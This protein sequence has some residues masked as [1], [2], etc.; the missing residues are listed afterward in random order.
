MAAAVDN[1]EVSKNPKDILSDY[2]NWGSVK[3]DYGEAIEE[4]VIRFYNLYNPKDK[5]LGPNSTNPFSPYQI[6]PSFEGDLAP[7][8]NGSQTPPDKALREK[9]VDIDVTKEIPFNKDAA[10]IGNVSIG[11]LS[12][13]YC[14]D[15]RIL[16]PPIPTCM[17]TKAGDSHYGYFGFRDAK[18]HTKL[19]ADG[20]MDVIVNNWKNITS[21]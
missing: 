11:N 8:Q 2:T 10:G 17:I 12:V 13:E 16:S 14:D 15:T 21:N 5:V 4:E 9:Y 7:G 3:S 19:K 6:Y 20:A 1:E 18:N